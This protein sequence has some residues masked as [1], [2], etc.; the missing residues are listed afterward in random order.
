MNREKEPIR[1][2]TV[3]KTIGAGAVG[4]TVLTGSVAANHGVATA[5]LRPMN[6]SGISGT[7]TIEDDGT[8][9]TVN[10]VAQ[11]LD[12]NNSPFNL[13]DE[14]GYA[15]L[16]Y[17]NASQPNGPTACEPSRVNDL[18]FPQMLAG[19][20]EDYADGTG[21]LVDFNEDPAVPNR[22]YVPVK[23]IGTVSIRDLTVNG[24]ETPEAVVACGKVRH[25]SQG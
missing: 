16:F 12:P 6:D 2:R 14:T 7:I 22:D 20:W 1:R 3:M 19:F 21:T 4:G 17:D 8:S 24:G 18:T 23:E 10:G 11:G 15:S 9:L 13:A 25:G 5:N